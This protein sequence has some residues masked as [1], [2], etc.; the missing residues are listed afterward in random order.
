MFQGQS[1]TQA[2]PLGQVEVQR[3]EEGGLFSPKTVKMQM[4]NGYSD[5]VSDFYT[6]WISTLTTDLGIKGRTSG[7]IEV[8][9]MRPKTSNRVSSRRYLLHPPPDNFAR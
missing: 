6:A 1:Q 2:S 9:V 7:L 3:L 8:Q 4:F 5:Q